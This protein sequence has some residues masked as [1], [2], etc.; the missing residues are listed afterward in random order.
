MKKVKALLYCT[1]KAPYLV[2][3]DFPLENEPIYFTHYKEPGSCGLPLNGKIV[4]ECE[5][6]TDE[7][8]YYFRYGPSVNI[9]AGFSPDFEE[10]SYVRR[11]FGNYKGDNKLFEESCLSYDQLDEYLKQ[12]D[13]YALHISNLFIFEN[14]VELSDYNVD[15]SADY[16][17]FGWA[18]ED[19]ERITPLQKAPQNMMRVYDRSGNELILI[20]V[21]SKWL[22]KILNGD[23]TIEVRKKVLKEML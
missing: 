23:K 2:K 15:N 20:S 21:Q 12:K 6:E 7:I 14:P 19:N 18:F 3:D 13:G 9:G 5:V 10:E 17:S 1:K 16:G 22:C 8:D 4:A 11:R